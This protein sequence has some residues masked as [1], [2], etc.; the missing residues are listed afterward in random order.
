MPSFIPTFS[1]LPATSLPSS[2]SLM[3]SSMS[4]LFATGRSLP[5]FEANLALPLPKAEKAFVVSPGHAPVPHKLV[6]KITNGQFMDLADLL[7]ANLR[8]P[9]QEPQTYLDGKLIVS[10]SKRPSKR[11]LDEVKDVL[12]W[13]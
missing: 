4:P 7:S 3:A 13:T 5:Q 1:T 9:E 12:T 10:S 6:G 11:R 8:S 2:S